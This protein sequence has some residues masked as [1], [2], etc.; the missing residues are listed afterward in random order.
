[1]KHI[2]SI[3]FI[4][5]LFL[6]KAQSIIKSLDGDGSCPPYDT[7]CYEKDV[8]NEFDKF[9]GTWKYIEGNTELTFK[10][11]KEL[12][13]QTSEDSNYM[14]LLV[15]E[16]KYIEDG[17]EKVNTLTDFDDMS[18]TGYG[19]NISGSIFVHITPSYCI[20]N[21]DNQEIKIKVSLTDPDDFNITG[22]VILRYVNEEGVEK[23]Q[24]CIQDNSVLADDENANIAIPDGY[25]EL[26]KQN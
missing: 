7:N 6:C 18:I 5:S 11:K 10:L 19:H 24:V 3:I 8:N 14:D 1:M 9:V 16:Y 2:V 13:Y 20:I 12:H 21:S 23:L 26:E 15:G 17:I 22:N 25:Y 4:I